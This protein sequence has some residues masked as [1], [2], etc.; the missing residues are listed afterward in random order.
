MPTLEVFDRPLCCPTG[1]CGPVVDPTLAR[2]AADLDW[3]RVQG[4][5]VVRFNLTWQPEA[6]SSRPEIK[7]ALAQV[8]TECLPLVLVDGR[9]VSRGA[10]PSRT[11]L[12]SWAGVRPAAMPLLPTVKCCGDD[13]SSCW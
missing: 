11:D 3:L 12:A 6:F 13:S 1:L 10:Y 4:V 5:A 2:F 9:V 7:A 8:G